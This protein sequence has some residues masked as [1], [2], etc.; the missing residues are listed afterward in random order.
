MKRTCPSDWAQGC[1]VAFRTRLRRTTELWTVFSG[2]WHKFVVLW[3]T[4]W[5][6]VN[7]KSYAAF[8]AFKKNCLLIWSRN[9][10]F[11]KSLNMFYFLKKALLM[12]KLFLSLL[13]VDF[14]CR[15]M[16]FV[17]T[18]HMNVYLHIH[19][20]VLLTTIFSPRT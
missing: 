13:P 14:T 2:S 15:K 17:C 5:C 6:S 8:S 11:F 18:N 19:H 12:C 7:Y 9:R 1:H 4:C 10:C 3:W 20:H 16:S